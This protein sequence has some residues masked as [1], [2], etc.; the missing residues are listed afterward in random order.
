[1]RPLE[2]AACGGAGISRAH[3]AQCELRGKAPWLPA[4]LLASRAVKRITHVSRPRLKA[5][6]R[7]LSH[8]VTAHWVGCR[9][10]PSVGEA[11]SVGTKL[12]CHSNT[13]GLQSAQPAHVDGHST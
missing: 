2:S 3:P 8:G 11:L 12:G 9:T 13:R 7:G 10:H 5:E 1:M 4:S 6:Q